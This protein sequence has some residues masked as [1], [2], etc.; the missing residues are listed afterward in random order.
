MSKSKGAKIHPLWDIFWLF[1]FL[2]RAFDV[3]ND[4]GLIFRLLPISLA[5]AYRPNGI[6]EIIPFLKSLHYKIVLLTQ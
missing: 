3:R 5:C 4:F 1:A 2:P 6:Q